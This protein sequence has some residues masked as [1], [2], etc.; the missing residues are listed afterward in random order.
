MN[1][2]KGFLFLLIFLGLFTYIANAIPQVRSL[3]PKKFVFDPEKIKATK[4]I[5]N[6]G[7][8]IFFG[9]G[10]C[11]LCHSIAR[12]AHSRC[13]AQQGW[14]DKLT[15]DWIWESMV[16]PDAWYYMD[17]AHGIKPLRFGAVMPKIDKKP[18]NLSEQ[19]LLAVMSFVQNLGGKPTVTVEE[20]KNASSEN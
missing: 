12:A 11:S 2:M 13:P 6:L 18:V 20:F 3:P 1:F 19:Q 9:D 5:V 17:Y 4:D 15:R 7:Q 14:G 10:K 8:K 16:E